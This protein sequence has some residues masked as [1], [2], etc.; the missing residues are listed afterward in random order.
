MVIVSDAIGREAAMM[1]PLQN[2][3]LTQYTVPGSRRHELFTGL[4][5]TPQVL[6]FWNRNLAILG[7]T[8]HR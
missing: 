8:L 5:V 6:L 1:I 4:T 2:A 7:Q 3:A